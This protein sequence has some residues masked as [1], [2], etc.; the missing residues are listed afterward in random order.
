MGIGYGWN[1][2]NY[3]D[4]N[5]NSEL[6]SAL[7]AFKTTA[8]SIVSAAEVMMGIAKT[9][10]EVVANTL[11]AL[12]DVQVTATKAVIATLREIIKSLSADGVYALFVP[13]RPVVQIGDPSL[14]YVG[15]PD[16]WGFPVVDMT[17]AGDD[18][19][20][21]IP[22]VAGNGGNFGFYEQVVDSLRDQDDIL[23]PDFDSDSYVT[24]VAFVAGAN[25]FL[26]VFSFIKKLERLLQFPGMSFDNGTLPTPRGLRATLVSN[27]GITSDT[28]LGYV[29]SNE[30]FATKPNAVRLD[31]D[32]LEPYQ[33]FPELGDITIVISE[34]WVY[35]WVIGEHTVADALVGD[36]EPIYKSTFDALRGFVIDP[37]IVLPERGE[38][39]TQYEYGVGLVLRG[40][41]SNGDPIKDA[42]GNE[43]FSR[44]W[45]ISTVRIEI[46]FE[47][48][49]APRHG[50]PPDWTSANLFTLIPPLQSAVTWL[51][52]WLDT[53][54]AMFTTGSD[55]LKKYVAML[56]AVMDKYAR[57]ITEIT[58]LISALID[59]LTWPNIYIGMWLMEPAKGGNAYF[60]DQ[61]GRSLF[62]TSDSNRPPFDSGAEFVGGIVFLV[63]S[64]TAGK[65]ERFFGTMKLLFE[66]FVSGQ[67]SSI[68]NA[69]DTMTG[70]VGDT[71]RTI[72]LTDALTKKTYEQ[73]AADSGGTLGADLEPTHETPTCTQTGK[74]AIP[75]KATFTGNNFDV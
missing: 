40:Y 55:E 17:S 58:R 57:Q 70:L 20:T 10:A 71:R 45:N 43:M 25:A 59:A 28:Y 16:S 73:V 34:V 68:E 48:K 11:V 7:N 1:K 12:D 8:Q 18:T 19:Y 51:T 65:C 61:L 6:L 13:A 14:I 64:Q 60:L 24:S 62:D 3:L 69:I 54:E 5:Q 31:W 33:T 72:A 27:P 52:Q 74:S 32:R 9:T 36:I 35:R 46:P 56:Q 50:T 22:P 66:G 29:V 42:N 21:I 44:P 75:R 23:R 37:T 2:V 4:P 67:K 15:P 47:I 63:G 30:D 53:I 49:L 38:R 26:E 41:D 39:A